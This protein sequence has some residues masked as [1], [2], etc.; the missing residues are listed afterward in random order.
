MT[1][2]K[3]STEQ[4]KELLTN[5]N[6]K[7]CTL[8]RMTCTDDFKIKAIT[9]YQDWRYSRKIFEEFEFPGFIINSNIPKRSLK[10]WRKKVRDW[11]MWAL[12][13]SKRWRKKINELNLA[14]MTKDEYIEYLEAK[15]AYQ[16]ELHKKVC[17]S[18]YP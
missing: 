3:Y 16:D 5:P 7:S 9:L 8:K 17:K 1:K 11:W 4:M 13:S 2:E 15:I 6:V 10:D 18:A 14:N 12:I